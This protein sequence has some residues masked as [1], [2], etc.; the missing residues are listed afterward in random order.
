MT[1]SHHP[2]WSPLIPTKTNISSESQLK[3]SQL[4][5]R[6]GVDH[7]WDKVYLVHSYLWTNSGRGENGHKNGLPC[8]G[9][10]RPPSFAFQAL[11]SSA[12]QKKKKKHS[13]R[14]QLAQPRTLTMK[15]V[16]LQLQLD[17]II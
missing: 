13:F 5:H 4:W 7:I 17:M 15:F 16:S 11:L 9:M 12:Q 8:L 14:A 2:S 3:G 10:L 1:K 6:L